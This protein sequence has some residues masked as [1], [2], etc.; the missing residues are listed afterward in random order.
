MLTYTKKFICSL[1]V[2]SHFLFSSFVFG[3]VD[4]FKE[5]FAREADEVLMQRIT[6]S[7]EAAVASH[8]T[9]GIT[10]DQAR[11]N[12]GHALLMGRGE[13]KQ[14][15]PELLWSQELAFGEVGMG[16][17]ALYAKTL[18]C[19]GIVK[20][21]LAQLVRETTMQAQYNQDAYY[22]LS[23]SG[24]PKASGIMEKMVAQKRI[25]HVIG[26]PEVTQRF[27][28]PTFK[29]IAENVAS[30][31]TRFVLQ[32]MCQEMMSRSLDDRLAQAVAHHLPEQG[33]I[34]RRLAGELSARVRSLMSTELA[35]EEM[36]ATLTQEVVKQA[37]QGAYERDMENE[38]ALQFA[39]RAAAGE[40]EA[41]Q[42]LERVKRITFK[43]GVFTHL[44]Q[45][46]CQL[47]MA[48]MS[49]AWYSTRI[50]PMV[51]VIG[52]SPSWLVKYSDLL[53]PEYK[54]DMI[55][56]LGTGLRLE[57]ISVAQMESYHKYMRFL[58]IGDLES[59]KQRPILLLDVAETGRSLQRMAEILT[60]GFPALKNRLQ[61]LSMMFAPDTL[62]LPKSRVLY[63]S[64]ALSQ[65][66]FAKHN[67]LA[68]ICPF[69]QLYLSQFSNWQKEITEFRA[70]EGA[71]RLE[72]ELKEAIQNGRH[73]PLLRALISVLK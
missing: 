56:V 6:S 54:I 48:I 3:G 30:A 49:T 69:P 46:F 61:F 71:L 73:L 1:Y 43:G 41:T 29:Q 64:P 15:S 50:S 7:Y 39:G 27:C 14:E 9:E 47:K 42:A 28:A 57:E 31:Q 52:R 10:E 34:G 72:A 40:I 45:V 12:W 2:P 20:T 59:Q 21:R 36:V 66:L 63:I 5:L 18:Y 70:P 19:R 53:P 44:T 23:M 8:S 17:P 25:A 22:Y 67:E 68:Q 26:N 62:N 65:V 16:D 13:W 55:H 4:G 35:S 38:L 33:D 51:I 24:L 60:Q 37:T 32:Q 11:Y 58:G